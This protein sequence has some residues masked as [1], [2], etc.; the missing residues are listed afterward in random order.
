MRFVIAIVEQSMKFAI[1]EQ[2]SFKLGQKD[3]SVKDQS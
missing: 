2:Q 3:S 1:Q